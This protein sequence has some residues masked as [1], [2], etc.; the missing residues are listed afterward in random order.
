[1]AMSKS[2]WTAA[3]SELCK[4]RSQ[5]EKCEVEGEHELTLWQYMPGAKGAMCALVIE[6][7]RQRPKM[8][9]EIL[10]DWNMLVCVVMCVSG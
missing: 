3:L 6:R 1:M 2:G 4:M 10:W 9:E 8:V 7:A 5:N